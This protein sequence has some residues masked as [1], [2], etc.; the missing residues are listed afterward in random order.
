MSVP[1]NVIAPP[2]V[3]IKLVVPVRSVFSPKNIEAAV[4]VP[5]LE[6]K[7]MPEALFNESAPRIVPLAANVIVLA[8]TPLPPMVRPVNALPPIAVNVPV[9]LIGAVANVVKSAKLVAAAVAEMPLTKP[10]LFITTPPA[11]VAVSVRVPTPP[12]T[13]TESAIL[14]KFCVALALML[15]V[16]PDPFT[17]T[18]PVPVISPSILNSPAPG[19]KKLTVTALSLFHPATATVIAPI[20]SVVLPSTT[21]ETVG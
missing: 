16:F 2:D 19:D 15:V 12:P 13:T 6:F 21:D 20:L 10:V 18:L 8:S 1:L 4:R 9:T 7:L 11:L 3:V 17:V 5:L 14:K